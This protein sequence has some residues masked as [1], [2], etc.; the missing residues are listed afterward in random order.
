MKMIAESLSRPPTNH[1]GNELRIRIDRSPCP[2]VAS[3]G[4]C[5][6]SVRYVLLFRVDE[7]PNLI[8]L[9]SLAS[10]ITKDAI[11]IPSA[12]ATGI[13]DEFC[14]GRLAR[15]GQAGHGP[16]AQTLAKKMKDAS[17]GFRGELS[18]S[19]NIVTLMLSVK[20]HRS[21]Y[22]CKRLCT[23]WPLISSGMQNAKDESVDL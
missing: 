10:E 3:I 8:D 4:R 6:L 15:A 17:A 12:G 5:G 22:E 23:F 14:D 1:D 16:D 20:H 7:I 21:L 11:L 2:H 18:H 13:N 19:P 9:N